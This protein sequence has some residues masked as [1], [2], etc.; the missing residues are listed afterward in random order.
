MSNQS[1]DATVKTPTIQSGGESMDIYEVMGRFR[2][3]GSCEH[4]II[5]ALTAFANRAYDPSEA[6]IAALSEAAA[7]AANLPDPDGTHDAMYLAGYSAAKS[8]IE[9]RIDAAALTLLDEPQ[10]G[11][12]QA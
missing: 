10:E 11:N 5:E 7:I 2:M 3:D 9:A 12:G 1:T 6:R 8:W 4:I